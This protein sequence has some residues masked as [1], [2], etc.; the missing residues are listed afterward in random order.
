MT[1]AWL[2]HQSPEG[3]GKNGTIC[4]LLNA[5]L[6]YTSKGSEKDVEVPKEVSSLQKQKRIL[7]MMPE[8]C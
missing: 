1:R 5:P 3:P 2:G 7:L 8:L 6:K 4:P